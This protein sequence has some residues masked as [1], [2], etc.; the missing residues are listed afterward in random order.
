[1]PDATAPDLVSALRAEL[2]AAQPDLG[3]GGPAAA[4]ARHSLHAAAAAAGDDGL[5]AAQATAATAAP[6]ALRDELRRL[7]LLTDAPVSP[8]PPATVRVDVRKLDALLALAG[9]LTSARLQLNERLGRARSG[10]RGAWRAV[11]AAQQTLATLTDDLAREVLAARLEP[12]RPFLQSWRVQV[13]SAR[14]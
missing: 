13:A 7:G 9:E 5:R 4:R 1:M 8:E 11:R 12:A 10:E 6:D 2:R 14:L 3:A